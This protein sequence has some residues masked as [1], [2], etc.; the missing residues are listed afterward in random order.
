MRIFTR[1]FYIINQH[2]Y[3][4]ISVRSDHNCGVEDDDIRFFLGVGRLIMFALCDKT[5]PFLDKVVTYFNRTE[6]CSPDLFIV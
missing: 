4:Y 5:K 2:F 3:A 6:M 1:Y